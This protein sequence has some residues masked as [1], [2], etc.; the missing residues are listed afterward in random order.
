LEGETPRDH[1][2]RLAQAK[3]QDIADGRPNALVLAGDTVVVLGGTIL[4]KPTDG[5]DAIRMLVSL[6]GRKHVV[7]S[8]LAISF[9]N[10]NVLSGSAETEVT[11]RCFGEAL[12]RRYV[13]TGEPMDKAGAYGIQGLGS[14]LV[15]EIRGDYHNVMGLPIPL[16]LDLLDE[17]GWSYRFG[18]LQ[19][20]SED[21]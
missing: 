6:S 7:V 4:G 8:G 2:E 21:S 9:S 1:V 14:S 3:V 20:R 17:G 16:F 18:T 13:E 5:E 15:Q 12:A 19:M 10:G 11:F